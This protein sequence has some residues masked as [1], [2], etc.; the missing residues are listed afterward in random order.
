[1]QRFKS[2]ISEATM[3]VSGFNAKRHAAVYVD[4][5]RGKTLKLASKHLHIPAGEH[6]T[7]HGHEVVDG[8][9]HAV[10]STPGDPTKHR[11]SFSKLLKPERD[12]DNKGLSYENELVK[13]LVHHKAMSGSGAGFTAGNDFQL[14]KKSGEKIQGEAKQSTKTAA[15]GQASLSHTHEKGWHFSDKTRKR[16][17]EYVKHAE[18]ATVTGPDGKKK[19]LIAHVNDTYGPPDRE[20]KNTTNVHSD[21]TDLSP[22]HGYL[23][24]HHVDVLHVGSHGTYRAGL[25]QHEDR[26]KLGLKPAE[27]SGRFRVRQKHPGTLTVQ[28]NVK[29]LNQTDDDIHTVEGVN[30]IKRKLGHTDA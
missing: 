13:H 30:S 2:Y 10:V 17:P 7:I 26:H 16:F 12:R 23:K 9:H 4:P 22:M 28:F 24:D 3:A 20:H 18:K 11:V 5:N 1:M 29:H 6:V 19:N 15:F 21:E 8:K 14:E 27:G 25:S